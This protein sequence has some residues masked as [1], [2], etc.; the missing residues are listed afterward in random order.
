[1]KKKA[2]QRLDVKFKN[3]FNNILLFQLRFETALINDGE[4]LHK[5]L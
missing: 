3:G 4:I 1:M 5:V 2:T